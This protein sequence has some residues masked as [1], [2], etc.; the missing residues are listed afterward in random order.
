MHAGGTGRLEVE[1]SPPATLRDVVEAVAVAHPA[2]GRRVR[3]ETGA[4]RTHVN[5]FVGSDNARDLDG[6][7]TPVG[8]GTDVWVLAAVSGGGR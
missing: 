4:V 7:D 3:D 6:L 2:V 1:V 5:L 8:E